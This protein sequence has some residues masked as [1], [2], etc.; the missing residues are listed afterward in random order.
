MIFELGLLYS[1]WEGQGERKEPNVLICLVTQ[2]LAL[3]LVNSKSNLQENHLLEISQR[4]PGGPSAKTPRP[5]YRFT[6]LFRRLD[7]T[8]CDEDQRSHVTQLRPVQ[9]NK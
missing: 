5:Q 4:I 9:P 1:C 8:R 6:S 7:L 2:T 3:L